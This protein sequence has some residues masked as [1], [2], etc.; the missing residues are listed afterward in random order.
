MVT[1]LSTHLYPQRTPLMFPLA[2]MA[3][4]DGFTIGATRAFLVLSVF[5]TPL[6]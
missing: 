3:A 4:R 1:L 5:Y 2:H 6:L